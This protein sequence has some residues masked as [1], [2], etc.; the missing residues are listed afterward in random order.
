MMT[1]TIFVELGKYV[2]VSTVGFSLQPFIAQIRLLISTI[3]NSCKVHPIPR[4]EKGK[5]SPLLIS[6]SLIMLAHMMDTYM[7]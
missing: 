2:L 7:P 6:N 5:V 3:H 1:P 4:P